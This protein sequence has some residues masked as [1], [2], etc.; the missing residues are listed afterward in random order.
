MRNLFKIL[1]L[2]GLIILTTFSCEEEKDE[3]PIGGVGYSIIPDSP[4]D[5]PAWHP[6]GN[7]IGFNHRPIKEI[8]Y[9]DGYDRPRQASYIYE[10]DSAGYWLI[11]ADGTNQRRVL[12]YFL[13]TPAWSPDGEWIAF[14]QG[15]QI[16]KMPFDGET[17]DT[18]SI[19]QLTFEGRNYFPSW[20]PDGEWIA[21]DSNVNHEDGGYHIWKMRNISLDKT[22]ISNG[23]RSDWK[24]QNEI[25]Y[26][27]LGYEMYNIS[28]LD[29][30]VTKL[31]EDGNRKWE[32]EYSKTSE[33]IAYISQSYTIGEVGLCMI[34]AQN[35]T[36]EKLLVYDALCFSWAPDGKNIVYLNYN[37]YRIDETKGA[38]WIIN[39]ENSNKKQLTYNSFNLI[40]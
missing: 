1:F 34:D 37:N 33:K 38:L 39:T 24:N 18:A 35:N 22:L 4:Y 9:T 16:F 36:N 25:I 21:Y 14:V 8:N 15:A 28:L 3:K 13:Q 10:E 5:E 12:P 2:F 23:R 32:L 7:I 29:S 30:N 31:T 26:I 6:S 19:V 17:F 20:S 11:N 27:G 40:Q